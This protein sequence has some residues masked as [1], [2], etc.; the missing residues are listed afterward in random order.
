M[1]S[2]VAAGRKE[3]SAPASCS[4]FMDRTT[5]L[6]RDYPQAPCYRGSWAGGLTV[7]VP[8]EVRDGRTPTHYGRVWF[9]ERLKF[10]TSGLINRLGNLCP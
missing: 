3:F 5:R 4:Q 10:R 9:I 7:S 6:V 8:L 1:P 2:P